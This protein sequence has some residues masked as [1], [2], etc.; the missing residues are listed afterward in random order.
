MASAADELY[1]TDVFAPQNQLITNTTTAQWADVFARRDRRAT[2]VTLR[3]SP[4]LTVRLPIEGEHIEFTY[5]SFDGGLPP[6]AGP[7]LQSLSDRWGVKP[8]W[9]SY[10]AKPTNPQLVVKLLNVLS[11]LMPDSSPPP[12]ITPLSD[13][14]VQAEWHTDEQDFEIVVPAD[15]EPTYYYF[16]RGTSKDEEGGLDINF[17]HVQD[18]I[19]RFS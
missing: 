8:G 15:D 10:Q 4:R 1:R 16:N 7:V 18:V 19:E 2:A 17:A 13:G 12:Q 3:R 11:D 6:W 5:A 14:G 9:D